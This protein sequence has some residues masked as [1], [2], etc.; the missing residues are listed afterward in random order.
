MLLESSL[1]PVQFNHP[2]SDYPPSS[3]I[4]RFN[5]TNSINHIETLIHKA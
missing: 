1:N 4:E 5:K 2:N 3:P